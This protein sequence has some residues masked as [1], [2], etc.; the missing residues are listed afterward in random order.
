MEVGPTTHYIMGGVRVDSDTQMSSIPGLFAA[1]ERG[2]GDNGAARLGGKSLSGLLGAGLRAG[3]YGA[4]FA[5]ENRRAR[6]DPAMAQRATDE[7]LKPFEQGQGKAENPYTIQGDLQ[8]TMQRFV[9]I[10]RTE[11]EMQE[12]LKEL[13]AL[14]ARAARAGVTGHREYNPGWHTAID[15]KS[16]LTASEAITRSA[17]ERK[18][19][20]G[21]HFRD[22]YPDKSPQ[23]AT[24]NNATR[25]PPDR[26]L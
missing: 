13:A 1:G 19:S 26:S 4:K 14:K 18:E 3:E 6:V 17:I 2:R 23:Y 10:V 20:G 7:A 8:E 15:L 25:T 5:R 12:A 21:A 16:L 22:D 11:G 24:I 9:G